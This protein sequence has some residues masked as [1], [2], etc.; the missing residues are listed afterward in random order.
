MFLK[1]E[2]IKGVKEGRKESAFG[3]S[4]V[5]TL[6]TC[7]HTPPLRALSPTAPIQAATL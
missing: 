1:G 2:E 4:T 3:E 7:I 5:Y 6:I